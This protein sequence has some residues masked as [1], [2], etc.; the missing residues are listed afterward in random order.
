MHPGSL[1]VKPAGPARER[2]RRRRPG[3]RPR[4]ATPWQ[5]AESQGPPWTRLRPGD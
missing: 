4:G 1:A 5:A 3:G 2:E